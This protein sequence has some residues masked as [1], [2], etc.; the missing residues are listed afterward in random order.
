M[1][2]NSVK[3][4]NPVATSTV[5]A[6][7]SQFSQPYC[8]HHRKSPLGCLELYGPSFSDQV[9]LPLAR[10]INCI[11]KVI[12]TY[13]AERESVALFPLLLKMYR[14]KNGW[15]EDLTVSSQCF[16]F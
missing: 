6:L 7:T 1:P 2:N 13:E 14:R 9:N 15:Q 8:V 16:T 4:F 10:V 5:A 11:C 12:S 3:A